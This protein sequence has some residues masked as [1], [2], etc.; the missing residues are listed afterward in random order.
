MKSGNYLDGEFVLSNVNREEYSHYYP[1]S[2]ESSLLT[3]SKPFLS[4]TIEG[5]RDFEITIMFMYDGG[6]KS[7]DIEMIAIT[8][9]LDIDNP[10]NSTIPIGNASGVRFELNMGGQTFKNGK[11]VDPYEGEKKI[12]MHIKYRFHDWA[13]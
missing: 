13:L 10:L 5:E 4:L 8:P 3:H 9:G 7:S 6:R 12:E 1:P 11:T 2:A